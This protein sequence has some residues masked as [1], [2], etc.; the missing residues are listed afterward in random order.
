MALVLATGVYYETGV[1]YPFTAQRFGVEE[2][3]RI[4]VLDGREVSNGLTTGEF[5]ITLLRGTRF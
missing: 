1:G 5:F 2:L 3:R 4:S